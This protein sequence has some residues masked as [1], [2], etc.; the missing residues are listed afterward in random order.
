M[1]EKENFKRHCDCFP[2]IFYIVFVWIAWVYMNWSEIAHLVR[3]NWRVLEDPEITSF[4]GPYGPPLADLFRK[5]FIVQEDKYMDQSL[6]C[7]HLK[8]DKVKTYLH[9]LFW[10]MV[11]I[12]QHSF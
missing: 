8:G 6:E 4:I 1:A 12:L 7:D 11:F 3:N 5:Y 2:G 10:I 9:N